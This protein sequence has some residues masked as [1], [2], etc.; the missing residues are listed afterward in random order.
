MLVDHADAEFRRIIRIF[1]MDF[2]P[3]YKDLAFIGDIEPKRID[4]NVDLPAPFSP[5]K[6]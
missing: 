3:I 1:D 6:A 2:L 5:N 4:I